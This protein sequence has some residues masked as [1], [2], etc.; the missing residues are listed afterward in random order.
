MRNAYAE[1]VGYAA[2]LANKTQ[3]LVQEQATQDDLGRLTKT[4]VFDVRTL[5][6]L[7]GE[8]GPNE[9]KVFN[10]VRG[11]RQEIENELEMESVLRP[12]KER[13]E[14][15]L[16]DLEDRKVTGLAAMDQLAALAGEKETA[17]K[18]SKDSGLSPRAFGVYWALKDDAGLETAGGRAMDLAREAEALL[19]RFPNAAVNADEKRRLRAALYRPL[20][21]LPGSEQAGT[22]E[23]IL[24]ILLGRETDANA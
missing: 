16:K 6:A 24:A 19:D 1:Q 13:A 18:A 7:R 3:S 12:L 10:L 17:T 4:V 23:R 11:L 8:P 2:V 22:V 20:L 14:R 21:R 9:P 15:I 5:E